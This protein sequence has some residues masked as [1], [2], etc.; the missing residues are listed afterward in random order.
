MGRITISLAQLRSMI[1]IHLYHQGISCKVIE[2]LEDQPALV[3]VS[4]DEATIQTD[5]YGNPQRRVP[6]TFTVP[7]LTSDGNNIHPAYLEL[8][9][10]DQ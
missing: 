9:L 8:D 2:I 10:I 1:G 5:Q 7:V 6:Q 4:T 3:L